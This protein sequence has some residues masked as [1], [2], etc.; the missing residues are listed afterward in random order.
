MELS[1]QA[2]ESYFTNFKQGLRYVGDQPVIRFVILI[3]FFHC[4]LTMAFESLLPNFAHQ[5]LSV[6][7]AVGAAAPV[8][9]H[10]GG[11]GEFNSDATG[12]STLVMGV[13]FGALF[14]GLFVG[15]IQSS[16][17]RGRLYLV[18]GLMSGLGQVLLSVSPNMAFAFG[19]AAIM[20]GSQAAFMTMGQATMQALAVNEYRG[21]IAS[22]NSLS[23]GGVMSLM[24][25]A[26]GY[27]GIQF[28]AAEILLAQGLL[29]VIIMVVSIGFTLP[30]SVYRSGLPS[31]PTALAAA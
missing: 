6:A 29:Y 10:G 8:H 31:R 17:A 25:L 23:L 11:G 3:A 4:G 2:H 14:G 16:L 19:A 15:G 12:F 21:R 28:S 7:T 5:Q 18:M 26:N 30:R 13:G 9:V 20:G 24:N 1:K 22:L 27:L